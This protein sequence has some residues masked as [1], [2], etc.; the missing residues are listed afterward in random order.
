[1]YQKFAIIRLSHGRRQAPH[2]FLKCVQTK[3]LDTR[4]PDKR[5]L[6]ALAALLMNEKNKSVYIV[7][8]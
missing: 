8:D 1:M 6:H 5:S 4:P 3:G 7:Q 2:F